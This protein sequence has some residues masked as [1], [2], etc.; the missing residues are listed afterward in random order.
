M[1]FDLCMDQRREPTNL[2]DPNAIQ[3]LNMNHQQVGHIPKAVAGRLGNSDPKRIAWVHMYILSLIRFLEAPLMDRRVIDLQGIMQTGNLDMRS[4]YKLKILL[5]FYGPSS[6][7]LQLAPHLAYFG[8]IS[9]TGIA[10]PN[11]ELG[12]TQVSGTSRSPQGGKG[13]S[14]LLDE[15]T[16][17]EKEA[18]LLTESLNQLDKGEAKS[19][20]VMN[21][22]TRD[23]D[24][25]KL[26]M[27]PDPPSKRAGQLRNDLLVSW[28]STYVYCFKT[29]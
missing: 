2:Y 14:R 11:P 20:D 3:V 8:S 28:L 27:H 22:L 7:R 25:L 5:D 23:L 17:Q 29:L 24:V 13:K 10:P 18:R 1:V 26:P 12:G 9:E 15:E 19:D 4:R 6:S 16:E 21:S